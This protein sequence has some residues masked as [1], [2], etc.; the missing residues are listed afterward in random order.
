[1]PKAKSKTKSNM[2]DNL[3]KR[4]KTYHKDGFDFLF[5]DEQLQDEYIKEYNKFDK[6]L[7]SHNKHLPRPK[8]IGY[9]DAVSLVRGK[10][11]E[12]LTKIYNVYQQ[13]DNKWFRYGGAK[14]KLF[15]FN[16]ASVDNDGSQEITKYIKDMEGYF[17]EVEDVTKSSIEGNTRNQ[18]NVVYYSDY[19]GV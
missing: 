10:N 8:K 14:V 4:L 19:D 13:P 17:K 11:N 5:T 18:Y 15:F 2:R 3:T 16:K 9:N 12:R 1:M 7:S 6:I